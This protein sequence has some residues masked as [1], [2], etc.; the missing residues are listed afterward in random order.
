MICR[1]TKIRAASMLIS[2]SSKNNQTKIFESI[3]KNNQG[4]LSKDEILKAIAEQINDEEEISYLNDYINKNY[5][6]E[7]EINYSE[8]IASLI[9]YSD[10][11]MS[12]IF[13]HIDKDKNGEISV[14]E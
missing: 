11:I 14:D 6:N 13:K 4:T 3:D 5:N 1:E 12:M 2:D 10:N 7:N 9:Y 8:F